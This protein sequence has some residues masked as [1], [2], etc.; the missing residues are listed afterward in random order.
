MVAD[1]HSHLHMDKP[2]RKVARRTG[3]EPNLLPK[4][5][6]VGGAIFM[7]STLAASSGGSIR[8]AAHTAAWQQMPI[9]GP[10]PASVGSA[11]KVLTKSV[12]VCDASESWVGGSSARGF[13][14]RLPKVMGPLV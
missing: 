14:G 9:R 10:A 5:V 2:G 6:R 11:V 12:A 8:R 4:T 3:M 7:H 1:E 13:L